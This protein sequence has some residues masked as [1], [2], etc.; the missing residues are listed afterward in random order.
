MYFEYIL[1]NAPVTYPNGNIQQ[2]NG[3]GGQFKSRK[4]IKMEE[5]IC[6]RYIFLNVD[7]MSTYGEKIYGEKFPVNMELEETQAIII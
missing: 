1:F 5:E 4:E 7:M 6:I 3:K 2:V